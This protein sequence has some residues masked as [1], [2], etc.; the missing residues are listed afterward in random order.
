M[1]RTIEEVATAPAYFEGVTSLLFFNGLLVVALIIVGI[2]YAS[3]KEK[4]LAGAVF[5][6]AGLLGAL[7]ALFLTDKID[8]NNGTNVQAEDIYRSMEQDIEAQYDVE[9][10]SI[11]PLTDGTVEQLQD[12]LTSDDSVYF[13]TEITLP[14]N[15]SQHYSYIMAVEDYSAELFALDDSIPQP[16]DFVTDAAHDEDIVE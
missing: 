2:T 10:V 12:I 1:S 11:T 8:N 3:D 5:I 9:A 15:T 7:F 6:T 14:E 16:E 13:E 4:V